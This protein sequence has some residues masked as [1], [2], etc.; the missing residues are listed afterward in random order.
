MVSFPQINE[1]FI[2]LDTNGDGVVSKEEFLA[3]FFKFV[4]GVSTE[5]ALD[6]PSKS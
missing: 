1:L 3:G 5:T 4:G 2:V 6:S